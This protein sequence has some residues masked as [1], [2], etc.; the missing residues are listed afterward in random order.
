MMMM[1]TRMAKRSASLFPSYFDPS[2][3]GE[4]FPDAVTA[5]KAGGMKEWFE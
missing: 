4:E 3:F 5:S 2:S 1:T